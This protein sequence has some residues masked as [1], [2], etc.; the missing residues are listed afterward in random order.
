MCGNSLF[1]FRYFTS[2]LLFFNFSTSTTPLLMSSSLCWP[3]IIFTTFRIK[4]ISMETLVMLLVMLF[5]EELLIALLGV[6]SFTEVTVHRFHIV[7]PFMIIPS[8]CTAIMFI[9]TFFPTNVSV[10]SGVHTPVPPILTFEHESFLAIPC[11]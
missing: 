1:P 3:S 6:W 7:L 9:T 11:T 2:F 8:S 5:A 10:F 4:S